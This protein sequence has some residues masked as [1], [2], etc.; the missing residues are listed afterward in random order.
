[1]Y[2]EEKGF[3]YYVGTIDISKGYYLGKYKINKGIARVSEYPNTHGWLL[4]A[5]PPPHGFHP[6]TGHGLPVYLCAAD[7]HCDYPTYRA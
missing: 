5:D 7:F 4:S 3:I 6:V 1:M 2:K